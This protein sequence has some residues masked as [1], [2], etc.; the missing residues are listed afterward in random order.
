MVTALRI[1]K[2]R[3]IN[4]FRVK[5]AAKATA[6]VILIELTY[7]IIDMRVH[8]VLRIESRL[9]CRGYLRIENHPL[10]LRSIH[11]RP[12]YLIRQAFCFFRSEIQE[13]FAEASLVKHRRKLAMVTDNYG[14][15]AE[16]QWHQ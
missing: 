16:T 15:G 8:T 6:F 10:E 2:V 1:R 5:P 11:K 3:R 4:L 7:D 12:V 13:S 9:Y 14:L